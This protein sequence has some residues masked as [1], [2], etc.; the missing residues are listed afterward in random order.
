MY[1]DD[2]IIKTFSTFSVT[3][4]LEL[5][6]LSFTTFATH[7]LN[8]WHPFHVSSMLYDKDAGHRTFIDDVYECQMRLPGTNWVQSTRP[9]SN[10]VCS[11]LLVSR[12]NYN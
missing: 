11:E 10:V 9:W 2:L 7:D 12:L 8:Y 1:V 4:T 5:H 6:S 3:L